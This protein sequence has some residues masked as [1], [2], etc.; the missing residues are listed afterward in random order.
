LYYARRCQELTEQHKGHLSDF[1]F[2]YAYE[3]MARAQA[4]AGNQS[5]AQKYL[6]LA[7]EAGTAIQDEEDREIFIGDFNGG[8]WYG[9]RD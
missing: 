5:E 8:E 4:L 2:A 7:E 3:G 1:D 9:V 6:A